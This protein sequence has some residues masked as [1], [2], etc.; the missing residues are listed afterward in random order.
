MINHAASAHVMPEYTGLFANVISCAGGMVP[1]RHDKLLSTSRG[2]R[3]QLG[4]LV[5]T[6]KLPCVCQ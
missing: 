3:N 1:K 6:V 2:D 4:V 5:S